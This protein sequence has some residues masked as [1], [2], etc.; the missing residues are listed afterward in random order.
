MGIWDTLN[1]LKKKAEAEIATR[2]AEKM[3]ER[4]GN[5]L[6][7]GIETALLGKPG[8]ADEILKKDA[9]DV[10]PLERLRGQMKPDG[11]GGKDP[12]DA[13]N[14]PEPPKPTRAEAAKAREDRARVELAELK[15]KMGK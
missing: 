8:A 2:A 10:D 5:D 7:D 3:A 6:L 15:R 1:G 13:E 11:S 9:G 4:V 14:P 12:T